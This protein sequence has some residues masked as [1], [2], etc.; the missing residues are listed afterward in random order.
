M[1]RVVTGRKHS[2]QNG[3]TP[4]D[5]CLR[6]LNTWRKQDFTPDDPCLRRPNTRRKPTFTTLHFASTIHMA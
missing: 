5:P 3:F 4:D 2:A 6:R 1:R